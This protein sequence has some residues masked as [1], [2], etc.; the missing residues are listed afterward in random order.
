MARVRF[1]FRVPFPFRVRF[2]FRTRPWP[3]F[4]SLNHPG[5]LPRRPTACLNC[6]QFLLYAVCR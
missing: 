6:M 1:P 5:P 4:R 2:P 3:A